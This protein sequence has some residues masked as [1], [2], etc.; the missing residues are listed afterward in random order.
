MIEKGQVWTRDRFPSEKEDV[1]RTVE[2]VYGNRIYT[3]E[4]TFWLSKKLIESGYMNYRV[5]S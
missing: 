5:V 1:V 4:T 3:K 2:K